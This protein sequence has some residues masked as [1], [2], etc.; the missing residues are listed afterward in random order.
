MCQ[1]FDGETA[2]SGD[3]SK[4]LPA[5]YEFVLFKNTPARC[6]FAGSLP[7]VNSL[8]LSSPDVP[9]GA[10]AGCHVIQMSTRRDRSPQVQQQLPACLQKQDQEMMG[11]SQEI[12]GRGQVMMGRGQGRRPLGSDWM[13]FMIS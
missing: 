2:S 5:S 10:Q 4:P 9:R 3:K 8:P 12:T 7:G 13:S 11:R 6:G 1:A